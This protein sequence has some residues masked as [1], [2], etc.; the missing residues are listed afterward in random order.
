MRVDRITALRQVDI[1]IQRMEV[2]A[3]RQWIARL[4]ELRTAEGQTY[5]RLQA[6]LAMPDSAEMRAEAQAFNDTLTALL[7]AKQAHYAMLPVWSTMPGAEELINRRER[8]LAEV[9]PC[10]T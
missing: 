6:A 2:E 7:A 1:A 8:L 5:E 9:K 4:A 3:H 10:S